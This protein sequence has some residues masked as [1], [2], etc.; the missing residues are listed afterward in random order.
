MQLKAYP[1]WK[2]INQ[3]KQSIAIQEDSISVSVISPISDYA[4]GILAQATFINDNH[5][6][7]DVEV[8]NNSKSITMTADHENQSII[9]RDIE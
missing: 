6:I 9:I 1:E 7:T 3:S 2:V 8:E 5:H 4:F